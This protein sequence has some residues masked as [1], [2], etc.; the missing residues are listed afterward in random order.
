M[1]TFLQILGWL[2]FW[3]AL[4]F[5]SSRVKFWAFCFFSGLCL[6]YLT[7]SI[8]NLIIPKVDLDWYHPI[9]FGLGFLMF[10][11]QAGVERNKYKPTLLNRKLKEEKDANDKTR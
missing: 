10:G 2:V 7:I 6:F 3:I 8:L 9:L 11:L 5:F 1:T 4:D